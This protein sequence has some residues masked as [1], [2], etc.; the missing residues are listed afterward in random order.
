M[1]PRIWE[2]I[3]PLVTLVSL[4]NNFP[5]SPARERENSTGVRDLV[6]I[7]LINC[8]EICYFVNNINKFKLLAK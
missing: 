7:D 2:G 1:Q 8:C 4:F 3:G 6:I 5:V